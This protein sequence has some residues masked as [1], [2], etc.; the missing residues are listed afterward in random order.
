M[1][2]PVQ[3]HVISKETKEGCVAGANL[4]VLKKHTWHFVQKPGTFFLSNVHITYI[5][6]LLKTKLRLT[7]DCKNV[8]F[9]ETIMYILP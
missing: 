2:A 3:K 8:D 9:S 1:E 5:L 7:T 4:V 6:R